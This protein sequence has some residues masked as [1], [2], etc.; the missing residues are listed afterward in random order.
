M[1]WTEE[2]IKHL[3]VLLSQGKPYSEIAKKLDCTRNAAISAALRYGL[4][5]KYKPTLA[6]SISRTKEAKE[7]KLKTP[8]QKKIIPPK[9]KHKF[10]VRLP[11]EFH[12]DKFFE[13]FMNREKTYSVLDIP[14]HNEC[15]FITGDVKYGTG[16]WCRKITVPGKNWCEKHLKMV[17]IGIPTRKVKV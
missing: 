3:K 13:D 9:K 17:Y 1:R 14:N 2:V 16:V 5:N 11:K 15:K 6:T 8:V 12:N 10:R 7:K 4:Q